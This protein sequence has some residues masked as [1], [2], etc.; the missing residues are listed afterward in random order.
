MDAAKAHSE[1]LN[2]VSMMQSEKVKKMK[3]DALEGYCQKVA[4]VQKVR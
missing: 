4:K 2:Q 3:E 1:H